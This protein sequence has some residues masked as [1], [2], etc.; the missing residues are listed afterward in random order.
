[1]VATI[2]SPPWLGVRRTLTGGCAISIS[3]CHHTSIPLS[4]PAPA[5]R[6]SPCDPQVHVMETAATRTFRKVGRGFAKG[7]TAGVITAALL[8]AGTSVRPSKGKSP[9]LPCGL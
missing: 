1:M 6:L 9:R 3:S 2:Q 7:R 8:R 4:V 5:M